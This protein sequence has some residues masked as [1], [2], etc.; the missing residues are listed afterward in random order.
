MGKLVYFLL[1]LT[2]TIC[3]VKSLYIE[4]NGQ[5][6]CEEITCAEDEACTFSATLRIERCVPAYLVTGSFAING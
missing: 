5:P 2:M 1:S 6:I 4:S 3:A